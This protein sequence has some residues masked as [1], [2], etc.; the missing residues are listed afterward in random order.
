MHRAASIIEDFFWLT[1]VVKLRRHHK[2]SAMFDYVS[3][4]S[5]NYGNLSMNHW[6]NPS[7][8]AYVRNQ[9]IC[10]GKSRLSFATL[11]NRFGKIRMRKYLS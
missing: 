8:V 3:Q 4:N 9:F 11:Y 10:V 5:L 6:Q 7:K 1:Y 2:M